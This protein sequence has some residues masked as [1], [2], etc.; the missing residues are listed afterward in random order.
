MASKKTPMKRKSTSNKK[1][2]Y[3]PVVRSFPISG[4]AAATNTLV[5]AGR[6]LSVAN[7][8]LMRYGRYYECKLDLRPDWAGA[9]V[10]I[11]VLR[12]DWAVQKAFQMGYRMYME[13]TKEE[14]KDA[15]VARWEDFRVYTGLILTGG[16]EEAVPM[17]NSPTGGN[18]LLN[19]GEFVESTVTDTAQTTKA[20]TWGTGSATQYS[21]LEE[22]DKTAN[23]QTSPES[24]TGDLAYANLINDRDEVVAFRLEGAGDNPPYSQD[25]VNAASPWVRVGVLG[26]G[27]GGVQ[28]LSTGF[29]TAPCGLI[30]IKG[31]TGAGETY[32]ISFEAKA[33]DYKGVHAP[34]MLE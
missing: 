32:P 25:G 30:L 33:G 3:Y 4:G 8:R 26:S 31:F 17:E 6:V 5:D 13:T 1:K 34:S 7:R 19:A 18:V 9:N 22:Y 27:T 28:R 14:R 15:Q 23:A 2:S 16:L 12:N 29:F 20:F 24:K 11:F 21:L 10:E